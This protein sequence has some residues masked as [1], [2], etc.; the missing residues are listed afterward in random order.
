ME[1]QLPPSI[2]RKENR[3]AWKVCCCMH[4]YRINSP[5]ILCVDDFGIYG[6]QQILVVYLFR[7]PRRMAAVHLQ[8]NFKRS[9]KD[10]EKMKRD[11][12]FRLYLTAAGYFQDC[13]NKIRAGLTGGQ[14]WIGDDGGVS[15]R[16]RIFLRSS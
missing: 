8:T 14:K 16:D 1:I 6:N 5:C 2:T 10:Q 12:G 9:R 15:T 11:D 7:V 3:N 13:H 4:G